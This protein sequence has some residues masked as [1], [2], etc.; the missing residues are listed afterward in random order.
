MATA[1]AGAG[2]A[3]MLGA[4]V[5]NVEPLWFE[6]SQLLAHVFDDAHAGNTCLNGRTVVR[7]KTPSVT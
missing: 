4:V 1:F 3:G 5:D 2:M 6:R 7:A